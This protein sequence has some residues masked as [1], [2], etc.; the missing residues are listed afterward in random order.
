MTKETIILS[1]LK[2]FQELIYGKCGLM[3]K[4]LTLSTESV[5]YSACSF[6]LDGKKIQY[7]VSKIT[8]R[9]GGQFVTVWKRNKNGITEP[10]DT[11]DQIEFIIIT[12]QSGENLGQFIFPKSVLVQKGIMSKNG[13]GGKRGIR[14]YPPWD[15][16]TSKQGKK[17]Q[18]WQNEYFIES[19]SISDIALVKVL[20]EKANKT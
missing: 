4:N 8:P 1:D 9:K 12:S 5:D 13:K 6:E 10:F 3:L 2:Y 11:L 17:T 19:G 15:I 14:V 20:F 18:D 16:V 7:R